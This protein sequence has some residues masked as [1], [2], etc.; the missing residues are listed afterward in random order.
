MTSEVKKKLPEVLMLG[1][2]FPPVINGGLGI[3]CHDLSVAMSEMANITMIVP[4]TS[5]NFKIRNMNLVGLNNLDAKALGKY[6]SFQTK[7][8]PFKLQ[9]VPADINPYYTEKFLESHGKV[10]F[11]RENETASAFSIDHLYG[12]DVAKKVMQFAD[13]TTAMSSEMNFDI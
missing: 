11:R 12:G 2:E 9:S 5:P 8:L 13:I 3:A 10:F 6:I 4:K 7:D 1:W